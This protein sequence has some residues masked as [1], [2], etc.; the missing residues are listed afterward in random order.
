MTP[1][2]VTPNHQ[3]PAVISWTATGRTIVFVLAGTSIACLLSQMY[4]LLEMRSFTR[5]ILLPAMAALYGLALVD[6]ARGDRRLWRAVVIGTISGLAGA[7][8]YDVFRLPFVFSEAWG[9]QA[10][11]PPMPLF[12]VFPQFGAMIL[13][14]PI[15]RRPYSLAAN[16]VGWGFHFNNAATFGVMFAAMVG[17]ASRRWGGGWP[18]A[19]LMA[20]G[21]EA[22]L[23]LSPYAGFFQLPMTGRF[24]AVTLSAHVMFGLGLGLCF[25]RLSRAWPVQSP[26]SQ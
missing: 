9:W 6:R 22:G 23:L 14:E 4:G 17:E 8:A 7:I 11:V 13:G 26:E 3:L 16:L 5:F 19:V 21:I 15:E 25:A 1:Q 24:I 18:W 2:P 10:I 20:V 12:K